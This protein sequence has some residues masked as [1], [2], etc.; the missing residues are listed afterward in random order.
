[1]ARRKLFDRPVDKE[2][3]PLHSQDNGLAASQQRSS[4]G[5]RRK[6][7]S[8][9][10]QIPF[11]FSKFIHQPL[12]F[13]QKIYWKQHIITSLPTTRSVSLFIGLFASSY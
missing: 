2:M 7:S 4:S 12:H 1:M 11:Q 6:S 8:S 9:S 5:R 3:V 10:H 13:V